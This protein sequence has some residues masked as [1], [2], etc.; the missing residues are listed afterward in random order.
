MYLLRQVLELNYMKW[1]KKMDA[2]LI[3]TYTSLGLQVSL[4]L[5]S[6]LFRKKIVTKIAGSREAWLG[7]GVQDDDYNALIKICSNGWVGIIVA[8]I[9]VQFFAIIYLAPPETTFSTLGTIAPII[10]LF[11]AFITIMYNCAKWGKLLRKIKTHKLT[12]VDA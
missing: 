1:G 2:V 9:A 6:L 3:Q 5:A 10:L 8:Y 11:T 12:T 4:I 7:T